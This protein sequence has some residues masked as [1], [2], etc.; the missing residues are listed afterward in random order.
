MKSVTE[1]APSSQTATVILDDEGGW[2]IEIRKAWQ[3]SIE[4]ILETGRLLVQAREALPHGGFE[5]MVRDQLP[6]GARTARMLVAIAEHPVLGSIQQDPTRYPN[7]NRHHGS[8]L[9]APGC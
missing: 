9:P 1:E 7:S 2:A 6:F 5:I 3:R 4:G 8:V